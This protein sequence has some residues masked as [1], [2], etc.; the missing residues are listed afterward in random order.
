LTLE[1]ALPPKPLH[2]QIFE[3]SHFWLT[4]AMINKE[5]KFGE[6]T[7]DQDVSYCVMTF[8]VFLCYDVDLL[9]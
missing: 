2:V 6:L 4:N 7:L 1:P 8:S 3:N 9:E 5:E